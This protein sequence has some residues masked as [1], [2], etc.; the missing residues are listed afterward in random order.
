MN[1]L[2]RKDK[3]WW[4]KEEQ[5]KAFNE[6]KCYES[7]KKEIVSCTFEQSDL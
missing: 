7:P 5:Q 6:L 1:M 4:W 2:T 3:K